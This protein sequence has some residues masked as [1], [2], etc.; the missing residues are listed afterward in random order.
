MP[1]I[2]H[3]PPIEDFKLTTSVDTSVLPKD[4]GSLCVTWLFGHPVPPHAEA[5]ANSE[6]EVISPPLQTSFHAKSQKSDLCLSTPEMDIES[7]RQ[8]HIT[9]A[10]QIR[11]RSQEYFASWAKAVQIND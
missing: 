6:W 11:T 5:S 2:K 4:L 9:H 7:L 10:R 3:V 1:S 8:Q